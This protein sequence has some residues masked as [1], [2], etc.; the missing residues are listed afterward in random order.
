MIKTPF[1]LVS[2]ETPPILTVTPA[3]GKLLSSTICPKKSRVVDNQNQVSP[4]VIGGVVVGWVSS[5][6][7]QLVKQI[8]VAKISKMELNFFMVCCF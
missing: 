6:L 8:N 2:L 7:L 3:N 1:E 4:D 5:L